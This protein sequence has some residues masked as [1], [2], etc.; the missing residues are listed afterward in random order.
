MQLRRPGGEA[1]AGAEGERGERPRTRARTQRKGGAVAAV[2]RDVAGSKER[3]TLFSVEIRMS[4]NDM[5]NPSIPHVSHK[6]QI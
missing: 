3:N 5:C 4:C 2:V 6:H 1:G